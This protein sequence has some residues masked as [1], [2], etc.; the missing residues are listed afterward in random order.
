M[1]KPQEK[2]MMQDHS[3]NF[4]IYMTCDLH[5]L[6]NFRLNVLKTT[7]YR[8]LADSIFVLI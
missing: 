4:V 2:P 8:T 1:K 7:F 3:K 6:L 5:D